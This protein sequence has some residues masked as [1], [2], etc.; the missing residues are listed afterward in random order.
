MPPNLLSDTAELHRRAGTLGRAGSLKKT[1][2]ACG[3]PSFGYRYAV[4][5]ARASSSIDHLPRSIG[6]RNVTE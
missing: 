3:F 5:V 2:F 1:F 6:N 4:G